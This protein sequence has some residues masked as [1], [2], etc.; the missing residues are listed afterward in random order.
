MSDRPSLFVEDDNPPQAEDE[1]E[2]MDEIDSAD[3]SET[4]PLMQPGEAAWQNCGDLDKL[5][6]VLTKEQAVEDALV[7]IDKL[8]RVLKRYSSEINSVKKWLSRTRMSFFR[9]SF[10]SFSKD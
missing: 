8:D 6:Q 5:H 9:C 3:E 1:A 2:N 10:F 7:F 4:E